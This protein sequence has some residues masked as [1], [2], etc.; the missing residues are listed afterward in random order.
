MAPQEN[1]PTV[2]ER[3]LDENGNLLNTRARW[4]RPMPDS[5][6]KQNLD[7]ITRAVRASEFLANGP[8]DA[9]QTKV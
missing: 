1:N 2:F 5:A 7:L 8:D 3:M 9:T 6:R 4:A